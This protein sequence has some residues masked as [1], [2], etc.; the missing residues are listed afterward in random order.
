MEKRYDYQKIKKAVETEVR[1]VCFLDTN[2]CGSSVWKF[3]ILSVVKHSLVLGKKLEAD[4]ETLE[5]AALLHDY[6]SVL[7][8][9]F[10][11]NHHIHGAR[12]AGEMLEKMSYPVNK[13]E[14]IQACIYAHRG[15]VSVERKTIEEK[16][17]ASAD[18]MA[19][20]TEF[21]DMMFLTFG[22]RGEKTVSG[23]IWLKEKLERSWKKVIPEGREMIYD[24]YKT[25]LRFLDSAI[26]K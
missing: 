9:N 8:K 17:L 3:H 21:V 13:T 11:K 15:S 6:A 25:V 7:D 22:I 18:A 26:M 2:Q 14:K 4:L 5:L 10:I 12:L 24:E 23:A 16:I 19:H 1:R 20:I